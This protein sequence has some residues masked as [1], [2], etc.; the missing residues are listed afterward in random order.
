MF[1]LWKQWVTL[2]MICLIPAGVQAAGEDGGVNGRSLQELEKRLGE[3][4]A[5]LV[6]LAH[7]SL[8]S[9]V[10]AIGY[11]SQSLEQADSLEWVEV[12]F[13]RAHPID[14]IVLVPTLWRDSKEGFQADGFPEAFRVVAGSGSRSEGSIVASY[15]ADDRRLPRIAPVVIPVENLE[16]SWIRI[17]AT[18]LSRRSFDGLHVLQL[19]ELMAFSGSRNIALRQ[20]VTTSSE[21]GRDLSQAWDLRYLVDGHTPYL[22]DAASGEPSIAYI[23]SVR[24]HA[25]LTIDLGSELPLSEIHLH[26]VDQSDTVPQAYPG[27]LGIPP[28]LLIEGASKADFSDAINL[29][30]LELTGYTET[31]PVMMW[32]LPDAV[33]RY[34]RS[35]RPDPSVSAR[36]GFAEI[37]IF[38]EGKNVALARPVLPEMR[39]DLPQMPIASVPGNR[40][41]PLAS[42]TDGR[43]LYGNLLPIR[44]W[45]NQLARR[46][47]LETERPLV[48]AELGLRYERQ[49][50]NLR[51]MRWVAAILAAGV[52]FTILIDRM[53]RMRQATRMRERFAADLH[54]EIGANIHTIGLLCDLARDAKSTEELNELLDRSRMFTERSGVTI[55]NW[56]K[57]LEARGVC[58][59][60]IDDMKLSASSLLADLDHEFLIE[61]EENLERIKPRRRIYIFLFYKECLTNIIRHSQATKVTTVL[62]AT[63]NSLTLD[64]TDNGT[65]LKGEVPSSLKRRARLLR[66]KVSGIDLPDRGARMTLR[67]AIPR[68]LPFAH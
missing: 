54:D 41:R 37:E 6:R 52:A 31:G 57:K 43:N 17:E 42:L 21:H 18:R 34:V 26:S 58:E 13:D 47:D 16:A 15:S 19:A 1:V 51:I 59:D 45:M 35:R 12:E 11:R 5:H 7:N 63:P 48:I 10:G 46:H 29:L 4:D 44:E 25:A 68:R 27:N 53:L 56:T 64:V 28:N 30:E 3:I 32:P 65:G 2:L 36:F 39:L 60:L 9:G 24:R 14:E 33:C 67:L 8:R 40:H 61:G 49:N 66:G 50:R 55:R 62:K 22:M 38:S 20:S 23:A